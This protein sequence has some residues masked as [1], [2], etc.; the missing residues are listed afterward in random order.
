MKTKFTLTI[1]AILLATLFANAQTIVTAGAVEGTWSLN[2][3]PYEVQGAIFV[4]DSSTL[5][6]EAGVVVK[7]HTT[8]FFEINGCLLAEGTAQDSIF[9][10]NY[11]PLIRWGGIGWKDTPSSNDSSK[12]AYSVFNNATA[13]GTEA[14]MN[15]GGAIGVW[16]VDKLSIRNSTFHHNKVDKIGLFSPSGGAIAINKSAISISHCVFHNNSAKLGGAILMYDDSETIIDNCLFYE[17]ESVTDGGAIDVYK[18]RV[19]YIINC[20][21]ADNHAGRSGGA[22]DSYLSMPTLTNCIMWGNAADDLGN[23]VYISSV[24]SGLN[25]YYCDIEGG[26]A[27]F[28][29]HDNLGETN[30]LLDTIPEFI[31]SGDFPYAIGASSPCIDYGTLDTLYLPDAWICPCL[32]LADTTRTISAAIDLGAYENQLTTATNEYQAEQILNLHIFP[33][34]TSGD[35]TINYTLLTGENLSIS[36]YSITGQ[37]LRLIENKPVMAGTYQRQIDMKGLPNGYYI[38]K[39]QAG[40]AITTKKIVKR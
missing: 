25:I 29:G 33:N 26:E 4:A 38:I 34:P 39:L 36:L 21:F 31:G 2:L 7:F 15:S 14:Y 13:Y 30:E 18:S 17:N 6:I 23:Q 3:S 35:I 5:T 8:E 37:M 22:I 24:S 9:F 19:G 1:S 32:D 12:I 40:N 20:T 28:G 11:D 10:T 16:N 27:G